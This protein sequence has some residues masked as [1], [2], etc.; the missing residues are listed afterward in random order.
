MAFGAPTI[1]AVQAAIALIAAAAQSAFL[2]PNLPLPEGPAGRVLAFAEVA[3]AFSFVTGIADWVGALALIALV[4][5]AA[6]L[7]SPLDVFEQ[8][9]WAGI[10]FAV[11]IIGRGSVDGQEARA[12]FQNRDAAWASRAVTVL[13]ISTGV[14]LIAV[15]LGEKLWNP[16]LGRAFLSGHSAFN[17]F[18][19]IPGLEWVSAEAFVLLIGL[20][21][22]AIGAALISGR[23]TRLVVLAMWVPF[24]LGLPL[25]PNQELVGHLPV[26]GIMYVLLVH[27]GRAASAASQPAVPAIGVWPV[28]PAVAL[29]VVPTD[30]GWRERQPGRPF[31][32]SGRHP[33]HK[34]GLVWRAG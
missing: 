1:L 23:L 29:R 32:A 30:G 21:E 28:R 11:L 17:V 27:R 16:D 14:S 4:P 15:A 2:V 24:H 10:A 33:R 18:E 25:L 31:A 22:A 8:V 5:T 20:A 34:R 6:A 9:L 12:W 26:F 19:G 7:G 13:R 3:I